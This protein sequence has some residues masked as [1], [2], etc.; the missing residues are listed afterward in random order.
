[1][2]SDRCQF[3]AWRNTGKC[4][5]CVTYI[6][7]QCSVN[8]EDQTND[9]LCDSINYDF[10]VRYCSD[11]NG[12]LPLTYVIEHTE[13]ALHAVLKARSFLRSDSRISVG[14]KWPLLI[15]D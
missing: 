7:L 5:H 12:H 3:D 8:E 2:Q 14:E 11:A 1:M 9:S 4:T 15:I 10:S 13:T 6:G